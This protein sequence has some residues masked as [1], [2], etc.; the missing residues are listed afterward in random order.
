MNMMVSAIHGVEME[1][2]S[3]STLDFVEV[4]S[5]QE[6]EH[7]NQGK[8]QDQMKHLNQKMENCTNIESKSALKAAIQ[9]LQ[10]QNSN[11]LVNGTNL[12]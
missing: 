11:Q 2:G 4:L 1:E 12:Y 3:K 9:Y 10:D 6:S 5:E 7:T 8:L